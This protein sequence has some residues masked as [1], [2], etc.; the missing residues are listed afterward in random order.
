MRTNFKEFNQTFF[1]SSKDHIKWFDNDGFM[2]SVSYKNSNEVVVKVIQFTLDNPFSKNDYSGYTV[3][4]F[5]KGNGLIVK[6]F[7]DFEDYLTMKHRPDTQDY[8]HVWLHDNKL[9]WYISTP[10]DT[11]EMCEKIFEWV[12]IFI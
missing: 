6:K 12:K 2:T 1:S 8:C 7:F 4:I 11:N 9:D 10:I 5:D 3:K